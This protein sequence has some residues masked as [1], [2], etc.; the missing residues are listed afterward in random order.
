LVSRYRIK[1]LRLDLLKGQEK[2]ITEA[3]AL[4]SLDLRAAKLAGAVGFQW[5][6]RSKETRVA[7]QTPPSAIRA[8]ATPAPVTQAPV[9]DPRMVQELVRAQVDQSVKAHMGDLRKAI[10][11]DLREALAGISVQTAPAGSTRRGKVAVSGEDEPIFIP[12][13]ILGNTK[14]KAEIHVETETSTGDG[15]M[16]EAQAALRA[17]RGSHKKSGSR[18]KK[19]KTETT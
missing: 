12:E 16:E 15:G 14:V 17:L 5:V 9:V 2:F 1:D 3:E 11:G 4:G 8:L 7:P 13:S 19:K 6:E 18:K 10:V